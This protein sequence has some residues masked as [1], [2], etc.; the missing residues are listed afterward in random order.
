MLLSRNRRPVPDKAFQGQKRILRQA[1]Q[2]V[3]RV[4]KE[5]VIGKDLL[6]KKAMK[7]KK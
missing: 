1:G 5:D 6:L 3:S 7:I 4:Q 2:A